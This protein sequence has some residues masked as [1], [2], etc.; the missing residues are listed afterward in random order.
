MISELDKKQKEFEKEVR[1]LIS[2]HPEYADLW[3]FMCSDERK[4]WRFANETMAAW[5]DGH[6]VEYL[7]RA[8]DDLNG[9]EFIS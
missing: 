6:L 3:N 4:R 2:C 8:L 9:D 5:L 1:H 7:D